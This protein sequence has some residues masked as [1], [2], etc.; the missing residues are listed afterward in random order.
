[1]D[2]FTAMRGIDGLT[3]PAHDVQRAWHRQAAVTLQRFP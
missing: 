3:D 2:K 1:V